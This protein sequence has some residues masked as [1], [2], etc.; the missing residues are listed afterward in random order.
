M[1]KL[2]FKLMLN[3]LAVFVSGYYLPGVFI[4]D[5]W[6]ALLTAVV[7]GVLNV[8]VKPLLIFLALPINILTLGLFTLVIDAG[9][10]LLSAY[11][12]PGFAVE[13]FSFALLFAL[14]LAFVS[15]IIHTLLKI[16]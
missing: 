11:I 1:L 15:Y 5:Y 9:L 4:D 10:I 2:L 7:I 12:V 16:K 14:V 6:S 8:L 13:N 3:G